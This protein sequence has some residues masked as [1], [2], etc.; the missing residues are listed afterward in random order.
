MSSCE[1]DLLLAMSEDEELA[2]IVREACEAVA[3]DCA[4]VALLPVDGPLVSI[5]GSDPRVPA[6]DRLQEQLGE[7]PLLMAT[8]S[9]T[10]AADDLACDPRWPR[11]GP[12]V[13]ALGLRSLLSAALRLDG[14]GTGALT[15]YSAQPHSF[16]VDEIALAHLFARQLAATLRSET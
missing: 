11:W 2:Q 8:A 10:V 9:R 12:A 15:V 6:A 3:G 5:G 16:C 1:H 4:G 14:H 7:G 13:A